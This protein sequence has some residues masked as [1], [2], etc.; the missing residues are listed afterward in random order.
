MNLCR[1]KKKDCE[2]RCTTLNKSLPSKNLEVWYVKL[3]VNYNLGRFP[4]LHVNV[5]LGVQIHKFIH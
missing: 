4:I 3:G 5:H 1:K 2:T